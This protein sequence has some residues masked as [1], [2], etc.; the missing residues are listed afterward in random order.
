[1]TMAGTVRSH[2][3]I[4]KYKEIVTENYA[5]PKKE[6]L[7]SFLGLLPA[8]IRTPK[9]QKSTLRVTAKKEKRKT[10]GQDI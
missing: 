7:G 4:D 5:E 9:E 6:I 1:M 10:Q 3:L 8:P 2:L